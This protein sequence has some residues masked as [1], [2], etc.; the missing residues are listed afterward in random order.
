[1]MELLGCAIAPT[2]GPMTW[3]RYNVRALNGLQPAVGLEEIFPRL[4]LLAT[5]TVE[6][7]SLVEL[8]LSLEPDPAANNL[9][10]LDVP[11]QEKALLKSLPVHV[12][13]AFR[14]IAIRHLA[15]SDPADTGWAPYLAD[16]DCRV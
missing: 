1:E 8:L 2:A 9:L 10:V 16:L 6:T 11:G 7:T 5:A 15:R 13:A 12:L 3:Y 14:W 4:R